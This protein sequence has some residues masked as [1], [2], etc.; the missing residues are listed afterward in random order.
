MHIVYFENYTV[1]RR[2]IN[3]ILK[4]SL[5]P[6]FT[7]SNFPVSWNCLQSQFTNPTRNPIYLIVFPHWSEI[8]RVAFFIK[9]RSKG[10][11]FFFS[12]RP[13]L[14]SRGNFS[15]HYWKQRRCRPWNRKMTDCSDQNLRAIRDWEYEFSKK[16]LKGLLLIRVLIGLK[17][18]CCSLVMPRKDFFYNKNFL[19]VCVFGVQNVLFYFFIEV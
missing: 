16:L 4:Y 2:T 11:L 9:P 7:L 17:I 14:L 10:I 12:L 19:P 5:Q 15:S 6:Y 3:E 8:L 13:Y 18:H 1:N